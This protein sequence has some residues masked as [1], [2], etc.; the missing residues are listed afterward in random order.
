MAT[1][2]ESWVSPRG[3]NEVSNQTIDIISQIKIAALLMVTL[4]WR[5]HLGCKWKRAF[6]PFTPS[7]F[8][9]RRVGIGG[10]RERE[11]NGPATP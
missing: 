1:L 2:I 5:A 4:A 9:L 8:R 11:R 3:P 7:G 6:L 10:R